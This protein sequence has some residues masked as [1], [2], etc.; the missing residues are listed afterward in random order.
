LFIQQCQVNAYLDDGWVI[1]WLVNPRH[2]SFF[3]FAFFPF[4][5]LK[6]TILT[7][8]KPPS[9]KPPPFA[10]PPPNLVRREKGPSQR[11]VTSQFMTSFPRHQT[12]F[13][14]IMFAWKLWVPS[15]DYYY[16]YYW[17]MEWGTSVSPHLKYVDTWHVTSTTKGPKASASRV[18]VLWMRGPYF[19]LS[20]RLKTRSRLVYLAWLHSLIYNQSKVACQPPLLFGLHGHFTLFLFLSDACT[21]IM[22]ILCC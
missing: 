20:F 12:F 18:Y 10:L 22:A 13:S 4:F 16:Y 2:S 6:M 9:V 11:Q 19:V 21:F 15:C 3:F 1:N 5:Y 8:S 7:P 17:A 14:L